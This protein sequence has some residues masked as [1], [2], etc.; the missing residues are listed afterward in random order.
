[1]EILQYKEEKEK[2]QMEFDEKT[3]VLNRKFVLE[4]KKFKVGDIIKD[5]SASIKITN[6]NYS[7]LGSNIPLIRYKG[8]LLKKDLTPTKKEIFETIF[9]EYAE[10]IN[11]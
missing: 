5:S 11:Q 1:M 3:R 4:N 8:R 2:I 7:L 10:Q 9:E 6:I